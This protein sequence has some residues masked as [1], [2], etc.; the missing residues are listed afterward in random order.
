MPKI[1]GRG[2]F[3][4]LISNPRMSKAIGFTL[5]TP[6]TWFTTGI[7]WAQSRTGKGIFRGCSGN[8]GIGGAGY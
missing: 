2:D 8:L 7:C 1:S 3:F 6:L 5:K 4:F